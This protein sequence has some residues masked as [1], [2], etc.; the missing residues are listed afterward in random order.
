[1]RDWLQFLT[2]INI[3]I[4]NA[5]LQ[6]RLVNE[7][8]DV[9]KITCGKMLLDAQKICLSDVVISAVRSV[10]L[11]AKAKGVGLHVD[12]PPQI[13]PIKGDAGRLQQMLYN[14]LSNSIRFT[15]RDGLVAVRVKPEGKE[16]SIVVSDDG[17]G[18]DQKFLPYAMDPL[19]QEDGSYKRRHGGLG[20]GLSILVECLKAL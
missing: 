20:I 16:L 7:L 6:T 5:D 9:S 13:P 19:R 12:L 10:C 8:L 2:A 15:S 1:M 14:L 11:S 4:Q 3:I 18:I 17:E